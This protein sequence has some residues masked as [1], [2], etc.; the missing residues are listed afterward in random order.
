MFPPRILRSCEPANG[1]PVS[2]VFMEMDGRERRVVGGE[3]GLSCR[4][5]QPTKPSSHLL[6]P[7]EEE[8]ELARSEGGQRDERSKKRDKDKEVQV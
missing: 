3:R 7:R 2:G 6:L 1:F 8:E 4:G 5:R